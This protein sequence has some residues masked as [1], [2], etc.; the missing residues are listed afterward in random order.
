MNYLRESLFSE[1]VVEKGWLHKKQDRDK[2]RYIGIATGSMSVRTRAAH[3]RDVTRSRR[4][5]VEGK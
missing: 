3:Q 4:K 2:P 5:P 1:R